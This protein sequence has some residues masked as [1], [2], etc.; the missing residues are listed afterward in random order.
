MNILPS[1]KRS[2]AIGYLLMVTCLYSILY[3]SSVVEANYFNPAPK[4]QDV[5]WVEI[6]AVFLVIGIPVAAGHFLGRVTY[7]GVA[8]CMFIFLVVPAQFVA[9]RVASQLGDGGPMTNTTLWYFYVMPSLVAVAELFVCRYINHS[10]RR[11]L[12]GTT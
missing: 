8:L 9:H 12:R 6:L 10:T 11:P 4:Y 7:V 1:E 3:I 5:F 2:T